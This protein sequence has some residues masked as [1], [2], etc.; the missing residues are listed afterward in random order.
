[1]SSSEGLYALIMAGGS[2]TRLWPLS[3]RGRPKQVLKLIGQRTMF[4][5]AVD[6]L[7]PLLPPA[8]LLVLTAG[9]LAEE[10]AKQTPELPRE[11]FIVEP[12]GRGTAPA[13]GLGALHVRRRDPQ[14]VMACL[15][16]DHYMAHP[17]R[18]RQVLRAAAETARQGHLVTLGIPPTF[19]AT[20]FGYIERGERLGE[21]EGFEVFRAVKFK[22]KP[23]PESAAEFVADGR[24]IWNSGMF[25]WRADRI[26][27]EFARHLPETYACLMEIDA[28]LG[29]PEADA[30]LAR[31]WPGVPKETIDFGIM[32]RAEDVAVIPADGLGWS[33]VGSWASLLDVLAPDE[34]GNVVLSGEHLS[35]D[36]TGSLIV[37]ERLVATIGLTDLIIIDTDDAL[38][39]CPRD[40]AQE[41]RMVVEKL[42]RE[43]G[44][45]YL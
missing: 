37:S 38:L 40:R 2:G 13:I 32:E 41:V 44:R 19:A 6:R 27:E 8:R 26:L 1:M 17:E 9:D 10:L 28:G 23:S 25:I 33:D 12:E 29:G 14:A 15:T 22:E 11:N 24:H 18:F 43:R 5:V 36:T 3:R 31:A 4:Q 20:G 30:A 16:A 21:F 42:Q 35:I 45:Q 39:V 34:A 7:L